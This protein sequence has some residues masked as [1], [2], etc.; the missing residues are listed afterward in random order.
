MRKPFT[1]DYL[2]TQG[3]GGGDYSAYGLKG[4]NGLDYALPTG[5]PVLAAIQGTVIEVAD[6][7][8]I[9]Y[10]KYIK[11]ENKVEGTLTAHLRDSEVKVGDSVS[12]GQ[13]IGHSNNTGNSTG[14]HLHWGYYT[15]PRD[16]Q[17]GYAGYIDQI[18]L[19]HT[20]AMATITQAELNK[21]IKDR[22]DHW[23]SYQKDEGVIKNLQE[24][25]N[26][27]NRTLGEK[28]KE[29]SS[30]TE[31]VAGGESRLESLTIQAKR[32]VEL[33]KLLAQAEKSRDV[34]LA[35]QSTQNKQ[36]AQLQKTSYI[37]AQTRTIAFSLFTR[38]LE[39]LKLKK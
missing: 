3:F 33:D 22:D 27:R 36:I 13:L 19:I 35:A 17:N 31:Q 20:E 11:I 7:G 15:F 1:G 28:E 5:T 4:H 29:I 18:N 23:N 10:G 8:N 24:I 14:P 9:G 26:D 32:A 25:I 6:E 21:I 16:R 2:L 37:T 38:A 12:E 30:L 39:K 34:C